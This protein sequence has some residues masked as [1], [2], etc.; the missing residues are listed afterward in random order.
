MQFATPPLLEETTVDR[1]KGTFIVD[2]WIASFAIIFYTLPMASKQNQITISPK[3][4][5][6][7]EEQIY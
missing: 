4:T 3:T 1:A 6:I 2:D 5:K 7:C